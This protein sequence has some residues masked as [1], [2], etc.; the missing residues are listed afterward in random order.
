MAAPAPVRAKP[1]VGT[2]A[3]AAGDPWAPTAAAGPT[4]AAVL[5][6]SGRAAQVMGAP[7]APSTEVRLASG[8]PR[9]FDG[10]EL[11]GVRHELL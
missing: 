6:G 10:D 7:C 1:R 4:P 5:P 11:R 3:S 2:T 8:V 9:R